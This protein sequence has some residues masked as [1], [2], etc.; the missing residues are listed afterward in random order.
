MG[1]LY[2]VSCHFQGSNQDS[3]RLKKQSQCNEPGFRPPT[4]AQDLKNQR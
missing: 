2:L 4:G 3:A 1:I